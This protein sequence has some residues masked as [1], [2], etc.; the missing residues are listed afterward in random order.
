MRN[1]TW[2]GRAAPRAFSAMTSRISSVG[3]GG[4]GSSSAGRGRSRPAAG[5]VLGRT[6]AGC[7]LAA[8]AA[9]ASLS[10]GDRSSEAAAATITS[11]PTSRA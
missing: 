5:G 7:G 1:A 2:P 10:P 9:G 11:A 6:G 8:G 3:I 4:P